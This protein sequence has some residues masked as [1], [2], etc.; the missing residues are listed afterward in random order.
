MRS[1]IPTP[2]MMMMMKVIHGRFHVVRYDLMLL[3]LII[4]MIAKKSNQMASLPSAG[5]CGY[6]HPSIPYQTTVTK[7]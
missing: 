3:K 6:A 2:K 5:S 1:D 7:I 4:A